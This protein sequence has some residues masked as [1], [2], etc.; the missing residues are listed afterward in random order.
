[1]WWFDPTRRSVSWLIMISQRN[2]FRSRTFRFSLFVSV[3][4]FCQSKTPIIHF[5]LIALDL[6]VIMASTAKCGKTKKVVEAPWSRLERV[7][8][9]P[10]PCGTEILSLA[11]PASAAARSCSD[12]SRMARYLTVTATVLPSGPYAH[13]PATMISGSRTL[14]D[15]SGVVPSS[16]QPFFA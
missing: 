2:L 12:V 14:L 3:S 4:F 7:A 13:S 8:A 1:M 15:S 10:G 6:C 5:S 16:F 9:R 11:S